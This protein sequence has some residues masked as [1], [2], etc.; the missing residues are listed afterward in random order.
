V[1]YHSL[2][3]AESVLFRRASDA[4]GN[5]W[6]PLAVVNIDQVPGSGGALVP[7]AVMVG[8]VPWAFWVE[9]TTDL[10]YFSHA[11]NSGAL[12]WTDADIVAFDPSVDVDETVIPSAAEINGV[13]AVAYATTDDEFKLALYY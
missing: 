7:T 6:N 2:D 3:N 5:T 8:D 1:V 12:T 9:P 10:L 4:S 11:T 13:P